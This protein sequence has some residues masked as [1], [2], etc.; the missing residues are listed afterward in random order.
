MELW[1]LNNFSTLALAVV[2]VGGVIVLAVTGSAV[3]RR[4]YPATAQ[5]AH[6]DMVGVVLGMFGAIYGVILAFVIVNLW[7][8]LQSAET[9]VATEASAAAQIVRDADAFPPEHREPIDAAV[10]AYVHAVVE[11]QWPLMQAGSGDYARTAPKLEAVYQAMRAYTPESQTEQTFYQQAVGSLD[12]VVAQRRARITQ[13]HQ[14]LPVLLQVL[15][16]GGAVVILPLTFLYGIHSRRIQLL[17]VGSVAG[18][19]GFSLL[20]VLVLD[21][22]FAGELCVSPQPF[23]DGALVRFWP[24]S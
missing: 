6:N 8:Q 21:R 23:K 17:F 5:G 19:I 13:S 3:T 12:Q 15:V 4:R 24:G 2:V 18:L 16:Y 1:L 14:Q 7:T 9:V 20:L 22:P 11:Q 10:G